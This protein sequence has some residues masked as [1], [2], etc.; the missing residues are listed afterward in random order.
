MEITKNKLIHNLT[1]KWI[2]TETYLTDKLLFPFLLVYVDLKQYPDWLIGLSS[3][4]KIIVI[5]I[6]YA[7]AL[8]TL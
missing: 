4:F 6:L 2:L 5:E 1:I 3:R 7:A 8:N